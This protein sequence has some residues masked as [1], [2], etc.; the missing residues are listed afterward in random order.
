VPHNCGTRLWE[1]L[2]N[3]HTTER[4]VLPLRQLLLELINWLLQTQPGC[5]DFKT[6]ANQTKPTVVVNAARCLCQYHCLDGTVQ[7][8]PRNLCLSTADGTF[9]GATNAITATVTT[10]G[11]YK[12][13]VTN[14]TTG[15]SL[16]SNKL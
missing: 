11:T 8:L 2:V 3:W 10:A 4:N 16:I 14:T 6:A 12:L 5:S 1:L 7:S 13:T 9:S 15:C